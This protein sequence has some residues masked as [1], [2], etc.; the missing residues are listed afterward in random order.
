MIKRIVFFVLS[1]LLSINYM[2]V[3]PIIN[4]IYNEPV[5]VVKCSATSLSGIKE[6]F[7]NLFVGK[8][9]SNDNESYNPIDV[10]VGG[11]PLGFTISCNGVIVV[12][13]SNVITASGSK[14]PTENSNI[15]E[16]DILTHISGEEIKSADD[17]ERIINNDDRKGKIINVEILRGDRIHTT[18][19]EPQ[20]DSV[21]GRYKLGLWI[22]DNAAGVGTLTYIREDNKRFGALGHPVCDIDTGSAMNVR[23]GNIFNCNIV[24]VNKGKRGTPGELRGMFLKNGKTIGQLDTNSEVG[25]FGTFN[26]DAN[27]FTSGRKMKTASRGQVKTGKAQILCTINSTTPQYFDI[28][29]VKLNYQSTLNKKSMVIRIVDEDLISATG[30]IVQGMSGSPIIQDNKLVGAMTHVFVNDPTKGFAVYID[31]MINN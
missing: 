14:N 20:L 4:P 24:G 13:I 30:G 25:V 8:K 26:G 19:I 12:A 11:N 1:L 16:G 3:S 18:K 23:D 9:T 2:L 22:R 7:R 6:F 31:L 21:S 10:Y 28:E 5:E 17:I 29:I 15:K 27:K